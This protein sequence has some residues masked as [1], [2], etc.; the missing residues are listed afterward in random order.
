MFIEEVECGNRIEGIEYRERIGAYALIV[1][2]DNEIALVRRDN[3]YF[4]P[5]GGVEKDETYE[6]CLKR[7]CSEELGY[8]IEVAQYVGKLSHYTKA[9]RREEYL[10]LVGH[11]HIANLL[12][13]NSLKVEEDHELV[14]VPIREAAEKMQEEFQAH[15]IR[16]YIRQK[17][18]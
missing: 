3:N 5:G 8:N 17:A 12:D 1:N 4:L 10:K 6:E 15:A 9:I 7:E 16:E 14:W 13:S 18:V 11:V 2:P